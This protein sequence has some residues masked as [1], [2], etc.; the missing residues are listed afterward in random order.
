MT[1]LRPPSVML[2]GYR[3]TGKSTV[4]RLLA[5]KLGWT[6]A[7]A[8]Q[9][10]E[11]RHGRTIAEIFRDE[12]ETGFR[13]KETAL[14]A[15]LC[16]RRHQVL[17]TGGGAILQGGNRELLRR[18]GMVVWLRAD[19]ETI[20]SRLQADA[21]TAKRRPAL[22]QQGGREEIEA[23]LAAREPL[24]RECADLIVDTGQREPA[25]VVAQIATELRR[26]GA[27]SPMAPG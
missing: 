15:E 1:D 26:R 8:D 25:E 2:I 9:C 19:P 22:T 12:G 13:D 16:S 14:L 27:P 3:G 10:L 17:A 4:A 5:E 24:Y 18:S 11:E 20:W 23:L 6:W 7:D 21:Q